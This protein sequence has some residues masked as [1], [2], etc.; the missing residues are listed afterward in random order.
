MA[1]TWEDLLPALLQMLEIGLHAVS[2][3]EA[4][5][6]QPVTTGH[7]ATL[8]E[9]HQDALLHLADTVLAHQAG[10]VDPEPPMPASP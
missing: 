10:I 1:V 5:A 6:A 2:A 9:P 3:R 8:A 4:S 7:V